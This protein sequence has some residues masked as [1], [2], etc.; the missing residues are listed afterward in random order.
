VTVSL[1]AAIDAPARTA[2][3]LARRISQEI[4]DGVFPP[5]TRLR[6]VSLS[7]RYAVS[8]TPVREALIILSTLGLVELLPNRGAKVL[9]LSGADISD[10]YLVRAVLE[11]E[12]ARRAA[13]HPAEQ[14]IATLHFSC[15]RLGKLHHAPAGEQLAADTFFHYAIAEASGSPRLHG[16]I[17]QVC[18]I[19]EA[20]RSSTPYTSHDMV[21][22]EEQHRAVAEAIE[23]R[24][25]AQA[26]RLMRSHV[27]WAG[28][29]AV[30]RLI[31]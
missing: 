23:R 11:A 22:A 25:P 16:M 6:E 3:V 17:R 21:A 7:E 10:V 4:L 9:K 30:T 31:V 27:E 28:E 24:R 19:P 8:R 14:F 13:A 12:A 29:L 20:Y 5:G 2:D 1:A 18:A 15:D 26:S